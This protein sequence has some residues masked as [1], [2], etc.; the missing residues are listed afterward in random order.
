MITAVRTSFRWCWNKIRALSHGFVR[1]KLCIIEA[2]WI[3]GCSLQSSIFTRSFYTHCI[4]KFD[5]LYTCN[6]AQAY[7]LCPWTITTN[8]NSINHGV[9]GIFCDVIQAQLKCCHHHTGLQLAPSGQQKSVGTETQLF[10]LTSNLSWAEWLG[11]TQR[12]LRL[13]AVLKTQSRTKT[14]TWNSQKFKISLI[15]WMLFESI[16]LLAYLQNSL[17]CF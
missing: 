10:L 1:P 7:T 8:L 9:D 16:G 11:G 13:E 15:N 6:W 2:R 14:S 17:G 4:G 5:Y 3:I 12:V